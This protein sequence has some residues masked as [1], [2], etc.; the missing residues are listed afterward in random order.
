MKWCGFG[1]DILGWISEFMMGRKMIV[2]VN[3]TN[4]RWVEVFSGVRQGSVLGSLLFLLY[5]NDIP[6]RVKS[7]VKLFADYTKIWNR[8]SEGTSSQALQQDLECL[9]EWSRKCLIQFNFEK[10][11]VLH[12]GHKSNTKYY[13]HKDVQRC[14]IAVS[15]LEKDLRI[16]V[17]DY[18]K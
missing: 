14:E 3:G 2:A 16:W 8:V 9:E 13:L 17:S 11:H 6:H 10:C 5:V 1:G 7:K 4:S 18:L 12:I 15:R